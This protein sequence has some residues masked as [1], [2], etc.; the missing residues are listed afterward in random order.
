MM[1]M[2][3]AYAL[4]EIKNLANSLPLEGAFIMD[5]QDGIP[6]FRASNHIR[7]RVEFLLFKE[8]ESELTDNETMEFNQYEEMDDFLSFLNRVIRNLYIH[9]QAKLH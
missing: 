1:D 9:Q 3:M 2:G 7:D 5:L 6:V 4:P 8:K